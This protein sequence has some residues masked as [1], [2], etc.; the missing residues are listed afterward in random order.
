MVPSLRAGLDVLA[1]IGQTT[2]LGWQVIGGRGECGTCGALGAPI[3]LARRLAETSGEH[4]RREHGPA[5]HAQGSG[6]PLDVCDGERWGSHRKVSIR[7]RRQRLRLSALAPLALPLSTL[8][9]T[10]PPAPRWS[11][12]TLVTTRGG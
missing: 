6:A 2:T 12:T 3:S 10:S 8:E 4:D 9:R 7:Y 1:P 5:V 11:H